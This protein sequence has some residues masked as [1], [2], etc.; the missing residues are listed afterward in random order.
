[1]WV[2]RLILAWIALHGILRV[3]ARGTAA[4]GGTF[5][6]Q[7]DLVVRQVGDEKCLVEPPRGTR[8]V[9]P[10]AVGA[11]ADDI[12]AV[13]HEHPSGHLRYLEKSLGRF[14]AAAARS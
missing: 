13:H 6:H 3:L 9:L 10:P 14:S 1:M 8:T 2:A 4:L 11:G 7:H 12:G 5:E